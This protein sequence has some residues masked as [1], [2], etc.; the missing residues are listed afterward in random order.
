MD[1][2]GV[3]GDRRVGLGQSAEERDPAVARGHRDRL[4]LGDVGGGGGDD[5]VGAT[6]AGELH[7]LLDDVDLGRVDDVVGGDGVGRHL[8]ALGVDVDEDDGSDLVDA[9]GDPD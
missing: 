6:T 2:V 5:D 9:A 7:D 3:A 4:L 8:E 1:D